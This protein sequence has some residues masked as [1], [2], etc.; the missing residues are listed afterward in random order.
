L[1]AET[2]PTNAQ[3]RLALGIRRSTSASC[4]QLDLSRGIGEFCLTDSSQEWCVEMRGPNLSVV[5]PAFN[6][7]RYI[8]ETLGHIEAAAKFFDGQ[9]QVMIVDDGSTDDTIRVLNDFSRQT[10]LNLVVETIPNSGVFIACW[11]GAELAEYD[12]IV[13][14]NSRQLVR[15]DFFLEWQSAFVGRPDVKS[16]VSHVETDV[17]APLVG[18]FWSVPTAVFWGGYWRN[19]T[20]TFITPHNFDRVPKGT[21]GLFILRGL[22]LDACEAVKPSENQKFVSDDTKLLRYV[23]GLTPIVIEPR[24]FSTYR[25]RTSVVP[26]LRHGFNRGTLFIDSYM[27]T[28]PLR[29]TVLATLTIGPIL[30]IMVSVLLPELQV[31][32][33][34]GL[35]LAFGLTTASI[36]VIGWLNKAPARA[37]Q[38]F[39]VFA[40]P[41]AVVFWAGL[42]RGIFVHWKSIRPRSGKS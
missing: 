12:W 5:I 16:W 15:Q 24:I 13:I 23:C 10:S 28:S 8:S 3:S 30:A 17:T 29:F 26:F 38:S 7:S 6:A 32:T 41:F 25:P 27:S 4:G 33:A 39:A 21:G 35:A 19:K 31:I 1:R 22:F 34:A 14:L 2:P 18:H 36:L 9:I 11:R 40:I 37:L 42:V 20:R